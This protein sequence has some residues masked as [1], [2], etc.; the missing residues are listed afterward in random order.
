MLAHNWAELGAT[1][2]LDDSTDAEAR[3]AISCITGGNFLL[4]QLL[5]S[6]IVRI[7]EINRQRTIT[8]EVVDT[9]REGLVIGPL[10]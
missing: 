4:M 9:A 8:K 7:L 1:F 5:S 6:Q 2:A 3:A 10:P